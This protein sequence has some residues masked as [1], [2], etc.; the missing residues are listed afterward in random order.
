MASSED[1]GGGIEVP[2]VWLGPEDVP[3]LHVNAMVSQFDP[4]TLDSLILTF[5][6]VTPPAIVG[7]TD[8]ERR[9]QLE[10]VAYVPVKPISRLSLT[11]ARARELVATLEANLDQLEQAR[12]M[13]PEDPR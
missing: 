4:T 6:Q 5:G 1:A 7:A 11:V 9:E 13:R 12:T 10:Q 8:D 3:I 2:L